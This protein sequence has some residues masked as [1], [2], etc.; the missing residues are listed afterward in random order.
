MKGIVWIRRDIR[1][2]DHHAMSIATAE[3]SKVYP[4]FIFDY[5]ILSKLKNK[6][7]R[8]I[9][10]ILESLQEISEKLKEFGSDLIVLFGNP[11]E[12]LPK[13]VNELK[14]DK[15]FANRDYEPYAKTRDEKVKKILGE[16]DTPINFFQDSVIYESNEILTNNGDLYKVFTPYKNKWLEKFRMQELSLFEIEMDKFASIPKIYKF[17]SKLLLE[18][19]GF[20]LTDNIVK[21]GTKEAKDKIK[22]FQDRIHHYKDRRD[23]PAIDGTSSISPYIRHGNISIRDLVRASEK[24]GGE[25]SETWLSELVWRDFYQMILDTNPHVERKSFKPEYDKINWSNDKILFK[26]WCDGETGFPIVDS[27]MRCLNQTGLMHNRLRMV[28]ASFLCKLLHIDWRWGEKYFAEKLLDFDLA[29]NN[30]GWQWSSSSGCDSQPYFRIFNPY[31][32][33]EKFD[34]EGEYIKKWCPELKGFNRKLIH[35]PEKADMIQQMEA[36]CTIGKNYPFP[37]IDYKESRNFTLDV[38]YSVV[39]KNK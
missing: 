15:V 20:K 29:A 22:N 36:K 17:N 11:E 2:H 6:E 18:K 25:G 19:I 9:T 35:Q 13:I 5:H 31:S 3:C 32:Q 27:A 10:F 8:R 38:L 24:F 34:K 37:I 14:I 26:A 39:K 16:S 7:D 21:G 4:I 33:S 28:T 12:L 30:G 23:F 1:L